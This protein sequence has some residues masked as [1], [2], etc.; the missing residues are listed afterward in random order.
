MR[1]MP[2]ATDQPA[3]VQVVLS[4]D[5]LSKFDI[6]AAGGCDVLMTVEDAA[7]GV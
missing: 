6:Q 1:A 2:V 7:T 5:L 3:E 4:E